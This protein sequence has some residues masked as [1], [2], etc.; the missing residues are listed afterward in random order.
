[1]G[2]LA[3][4]CLAALAAGLPAALAGA[5]ETGFPA[6]IP[7]AGEPL[8]T[9]I[10]ICEDYPHGTGLAEP[11]RDFELMQRFG[12]DTMRIS[13]AWGDYET[14]K[15]LILCD[16]LDAYVDAA[17]ARGIT[18][19]AYVAYFPTWATRAGWNGAPEHPEDFGDFLRAMARRYKGKIRYWEMT[20]EPD[21]SMYFDG[22]VEQL[23]ATVIA[24]AKA[25]KEVDPAN[26]V[27]MGGLAHFSPG[28]IDRLYELGIGEWCDVINIHGYYETWSERPVES[29]FGD[30]MRV[31]GQIAA[32]GNKQQL[33]VAE[34]GY[35]DYREPDGRV[36]ESYTATYDY[37]HTQD[38]QAAYLVRALATIL[39]TGR[40]S[41][42]AWYEIK[43]RDPRGIVIGDVNNKHLG[44]LDENYL[45]KPAWFSLVAM[46]HLFAG[47]Y[48]PYD[49]QAEVAGDGAVEPHVRVFRRWD[50]SLLVAAWTRGDK[51]GQARLL[52]PGTS[53]T[54]LRLSTTGQ[55][56]PYTG[57]ETE[58]E[59]TAVALPLRPDETLLVELFPAAVPARLAL[60][61][62]RLEG[63]KLA[64]TVTN[65]GGTEARGLT[66]ELY[67]PKGKYGVDKIKPASA[68]LDRLAAGGSAGIEMA[69]V[70]DRRTKG[71]VPVWVA[72][73]GP[74][75][76]AAAVR[77][78]LDVSGGE[79]C[80]IE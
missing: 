53:Y 12:L 5:G 73:R 45:P 16:Y 78:E 25:V 43:N 46:R 72:V 24:G 49:G 71:R 3:A 57:L 20:N 10:G 37:E 70:P 64:C 48:L 17:V 74:G 36:S 51:A 54:G 13:I 29:V 39:A 14:E 26:V 69:L 18:L 31:S 41:A 19:M 77:L 67:G 32:R 68:V 79:I 23:A 28:F 80:L 52:V 1:M 75:L 33:W 6:G 47:A 56:E 40:V 58:G 50:G 42:V 9:A 62:V 63:G 27:I 65:A 44:M 11:L 15:G 35:S 66:V 59:R 60:S 8:R 21:L 61:R 4:L 30:I 34:I 22:T 76:P 7:R 2:A 55:A 38:Y